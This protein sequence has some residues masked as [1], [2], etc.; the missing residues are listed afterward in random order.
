[1]RNRLLLF[2]SFVCLGVTSIFAQS[3]TGNFVGR[4]STDLFDA[5]A[6]EIATYDPASK[7][8]FSVNGAT[9]KV[10][11][12]DFSNPAAPTLLTSI[13]LS[14]YGKSANSVS[15]FNG[16]IACAVEDSVKQ[17]NGK[18]VFFD[19]VGNHLKT[20][21]VGALP[22]MLTFTPDGTKVLV[23]NEGEPNADYSIDP[24]G[25]VSVIDVSNGI[26]NAT[27]GTINFN[28]HNG[29]EAGLKAQGIRIFGPN[30]NTSK[31][32]EP[33]YIT[34]SKDS[35]T[36]WVV[37]QENNAVV[38]VNLE[39]NSIS[40]V[41]P[42]GF[43]NYNTTGN[44]IDASDKN[45]GTINI[46]N[47]PVY[48]MFMPDGLA[49]MRFNNQTY[50][51]SANEGDVREY[52]TFAEAKR[53]K[54]LSLDANTFP[55]ATSLKT[56]NNLGRLN[57][58][59]VDGDLDSDGDFDVLYS[60]GA[61]SFSIWDSSMSLI[62]DSGDDMEQYMAMNY[63]NQFNYSNTNN[64]LKNRSDDKGPEP[65]SVITVTLGD[66]TYAFVG[67]ERIGGVMVYNVTNPNN[68]SLVTY[69][70]SRDFGV[71]PGANTAGGDLGPEGLLYISANDSPDGK[72]YILTSN[73]ISGSIAVYQL[74]GSAVTSVYETRKGTESAVLK[75][76][77]NPA[78][79]GV[80]KLNKVVSGVLYNC[81]GKAVKKFRNATEI[82]TSDLN[83]G[84]YFLQTLQGET[85]KLV[86]R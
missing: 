2:L 42:L 37:C 36:A 79:Q 71:V 28:A 22:D 75:V 9:G 70:T 50:I 51:L 1:M 6:T 66:S 8:I 18:V 29:Q 34:V 80:A 68:V 46:A 49:N 19:A 35:K 55:D 83:S 54:D 11:V 45:S 67:L 26:A 4:F 7:K 12:I 86:I 82:T 63:P 64:T 25:S 38:I 15:S 33:E 74:D 23:A 84:I 24:E 65:E 21:T 56:D 3:L 17:N 13:T 78:T 48:G 20:V 53:V 31:D 73:E 81:T 52:G 40:D 41:K 69:F 77:P 57:V 14:T 59:S 32:M 85:T 47:W 72:H 5:G 43:K 76:F 60:Y 39:N 16:V 44:G 58:S 62:Y 61:R 10:D 30:A 27:V